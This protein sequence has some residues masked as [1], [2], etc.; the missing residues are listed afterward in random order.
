MDWL[1]DGETDGLV[2]ADGDSEDDTDGLVEA[3]ADSDDDVDGLSDDE[4]A[5][6]TYARIGSFPLSPSA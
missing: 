5:T 3:D 6:D 1:S 4:V 2:L